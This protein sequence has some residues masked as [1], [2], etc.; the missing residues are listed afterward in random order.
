[1]S[2][3]VEA[4]KLLSVRRNSDCSLA[5]STT[6]LETAGTDAWSRALPVS[7]QALLEATLLSVGGRGRLQELFRE[8]SALCLEMGFLPSL[9]LFYLRGPLC[10]ATDLKQCLSAVLE[11]GN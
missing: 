9:L 4:G 2:R 1:M 11:A 3:W 10:Q 6:V 7:S 5:T 8:L